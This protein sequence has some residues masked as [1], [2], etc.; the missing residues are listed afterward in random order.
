MRCFS[1]DQTDCTA[2][3]LTNSNVLN[4][5][6]LP[7]Q[8]R[9]FKA[10]QPSH[11]F[12][13][14][15]FLVLDAEQ[16]SIIIATLN[17][18]LTFKLGQFTLLSQQSAITSTQL[19][20]PRSADGRRVH[21][22]NS[23]AQQVLEED[24]ARVSQEDAQPAVEPE[25]DDPGPARR[26]HRTPQRGG[27]SAHYDLCLSDSAPPLKQPMRWLGGTDDTHCANHNCIDP[28]ADG[29]SGELKTKGAVNH[30]GKIGRHHAALQC[31][32]AE[33]AER[34]HRKLLHHPLLQ[35]PARL[36]SS[37]GA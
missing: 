11:A 6:R 8:H 2:K 16:L 23:S 25:L 15:T 29:T 30:G 7:L 35:P 4:A 10:T 27:R 24:G 26:K 33:H 21:S 19:S 9:S 28:L 17:I 18:S 3:R 34:D 14:S 22:S 36:R 31:T 32:Q 5:L 20:P 12:D 1:S 13:H 37:S